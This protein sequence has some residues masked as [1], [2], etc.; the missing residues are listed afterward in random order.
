MSECDFQV[1]NRLILPELITGRYYSIGLFPQNHRGDRVLAMVLHWSSRLA[2]GRRWSPHG[3]AFFVLLVLGLARIYGNVNSAD[4]ESLQNAGTE[5]T[6]SVD[7]GRVLSDTRRRPFGINLDYLL[8]DDRN[9]LLS[10]RRELVEALRDLGPRYVRYPGGWKS[11]IN[12]WSTPPYVSSHPVLAGRVPESWIRAGLRL[13]RPDG[14]WWIDPLDFDEFMGV[15]RALTAEPCL[16]IAYESCHWP[17]TRDW[18]P[19][20]REQLLE[21]AVAWVRYANRVKNYRVKYW[22]I[23]NETWLNNETWSNRI[24]ATTYAADLVEFSRRMKVED[25]TIQIGANGDTSAWWREVLTRAAGQIDFLSVHSYPCW[26]WSSYEDYRTNSVGILGVVHTAKRAIEKYAPD[27]KRRLKI[28]LTEFAAGTFGDWD[29]TPAD[30]G[31]A[32]ITL[33]LQGQLLECP[34]VLFSQFWTTHNIYRD[35]DGEVFETF[36]RD[37][38]LTPNGRALWIWNSFLGDEMLATTSSEM[39][40]CFATRRGSE[41]VTVFLV[42][43]DSA[44]RDATITLRRLPRQLRQGERWTLHGNGPLDSKPTWD[45]IGTLLVSKPELLLRLEPVSATVIRLRKEPGR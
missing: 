1:M 45:R 11:A 2:A 10:P 13:T 23:G 31:R 8:D 29:K 25:A 38:T 32:L 37:N 39:I 44:P 41:E 9:P 43:K 5:A 3:S 40:R 19:P 27:H 26:K 4:A 20:S 24:P 21:T 22:E 30:L 18:T 6:L 35:L 28:A 42:N 16:V 36:H 17:P 12:L 14:G 15:C 34:D 33:D 7:C